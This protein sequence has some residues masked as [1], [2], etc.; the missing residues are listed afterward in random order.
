MET[1]KIQKGAKSVGY[2]TVAKFPLG[3]ENFIA[4][5]S[6][7]IDPSVCSDLVSHLSED[8]QTLFSPGPTIGGLNLAM[9]NCMDTSFMDP[10]LYNDETMA[11]IGLYRGFEQHL[12]SSIW[13]CLTDYIQQYP[14]LWSAPEVVT[15]GHRIQRYYKNSGYYRE[16]CDAM[17]WD[18]VIGN[19]E[20]K[21]R[22]LAIVAYLNTV[23]NGG[24]T[25]FPLHGYTSEAEIGK[26]AIFPTTWMF[27]H[28]GTVPHSS[29]KWIVSS[30]VLCDTFKENLSNKIVNKI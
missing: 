17:P 27:P 5:Y 30:F 19:Q 12:T 2:E 8:F 15:T 1:R 16:H 10:A 18:S 28:M 7:A 13:S 3:K 9:K 20:G 22:I 23:E 14:T 29:D 25:K 6:N 11:H 4:E 24:G 21:V 26:V